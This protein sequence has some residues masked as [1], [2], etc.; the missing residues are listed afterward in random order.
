VSPSADADIEGLT[1]DVLLTG[2]LDR[3]PAPR[4]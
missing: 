2:I 3:V 1:A 4:V